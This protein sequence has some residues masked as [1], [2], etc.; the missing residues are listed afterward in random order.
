MYDLL[1]RGLLGNTIQQWFSLAKWLADPE[2]RRFSVWGVRT[3]TPGGPCRLYCPEAEV[4]AT[5]AAYEA[6]GHACNI[7]VMIDAVVGVTLY[8]D[9]YDSPEGLIVYGVEHP[10]KGASWREVMPRDGRQV[11]G[12]AAR[13]L[14]ARHL[15]PASLA[16]LWALLERFPGHVVELSACGRC[17]G[18]VPG[19]NGVIWEVRDY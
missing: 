15:N 12:L 10:G 19:R 14:L 17:L 2:A 1:S 9:V 6:M 16:D 11:G 13:M 3:L 18:T 8:A 4:P 7:S 5:V